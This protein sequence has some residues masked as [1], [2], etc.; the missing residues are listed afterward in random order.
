MTV[1]E[2]S[3]STLQQF[4]EVLAYTEGQVDSIMGV[5]S[6]TAQG[7][8]YI[9][10]VQ[11]KA[12]QAMMDTQTTQ[13]TNAIENYMRQYVLTALDL[14]VSEQ[15]GEGS[16]IVDDE[17]KNTINNIQPGTV[18]DDNVFNLN[19]DEFYDAIQTWTVDIDL[20]M[21]KKQENQAQIETLQDELTVLRQ[22]A[23]PNDPE[24]MANANKIEKVLLQKTAPE[25]SNMPDAPTMQPAMPQEIPPQVG[26]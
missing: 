26:Q 9:N 4:Q 12:Q 14:Y 8:A 16:I 17:A 7:S 3:N 6:A 2:L 10:T 15:R 5:S 24:S 21:G 20:S 1:K 18:G 23:N 22:T 13:F 11:A 25:I 19:W